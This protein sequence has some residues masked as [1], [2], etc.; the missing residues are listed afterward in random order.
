MEFKV[1]NMISS[2]G[3]IVPNQFIIKTNNKTYFQSYDVIVAVRDNKSNKV[4]LD[5][6]YYNYS[7]TTSKYR[8]SFLNVDSKE[9][10][11]NL[12]NKMYSLRDL[13]KQ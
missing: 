12:K 7:K 10:N 6:T 13:N 1:R 4:T 2:N 11:N 8:N 3:N 5:K 9:F